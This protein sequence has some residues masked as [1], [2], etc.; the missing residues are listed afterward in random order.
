MNQYILKDLH[1]LIGFSF[2][3]VIHVEY[4]DIPTIYHAK[5]N[6]SRILF[7][8]QKDLNLDVNYLEHINS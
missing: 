5:Y 3:C 4:N 6:Y 7:E 8:N 1:Q 2:C